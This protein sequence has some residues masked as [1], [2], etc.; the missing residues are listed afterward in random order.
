MAGAD[1]LELTGRYKNAASISC[2]FLR[3]RSVR[4]DAATTSFHSLAAEHYKNASHS[5][6]F[7]H[8]TSAM[9][10]SYLSI[11]WGQGSSAMLQ[12]VKRDIPQAA[13]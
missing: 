5:L 6:C 8:L 10:E 2:D 1:F 11:G 9:L 12:R 13:R 3:A 7:P 4:D